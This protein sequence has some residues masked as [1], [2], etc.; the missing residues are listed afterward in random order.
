MRISFAGLAI[1]I[2][3]SGC[4]EKPVA[5]DTTPA[6]SIPLDDS[7][8][9]TANEATPVDNAAATPGTDSP[10]GWIG[11][12]VGVE[13]L[14][15]DISKGDAPGQYMLK[16]A[17]LDGT[18]TYDGTADGDTIRFT[19]D[20]KEERVRRAKGTETGLKYLAEKTDCLMIQVGEGFCRG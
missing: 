3:L 6:A 2:M 5:N 13:G 8:A 19:R 15:L 7:V 18:A 9:T 14:A 4:Q 20:G 1:A 11:K 12:W 17:L 16:I 10:E